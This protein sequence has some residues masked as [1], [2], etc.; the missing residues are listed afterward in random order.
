VARRWKAWVP[1]VLGNLSFSLVGRRG[2]PFPFFSLKS[3]H[4]EGGY[5]VF[6]ER[7][8]PDVKLPILCALPSRVYLRLSYGLLHCIKGESFF[9]YFMVA[10]KGDEADRAT[11]AVQSVR[12]TIHLF[13]RLPRRELH[14]F[15][16]KLDLTDETPPYDELRETVE[17]WFRQGGGKPG[18]KAKIEFTLDRQGFCEF[19]E[20]DIDGFENEEVDEKSAD[21]VADMAFYFLRDV[22]H[23]HKHH[24]R[25][26]E[27]LIH[28]Y[29]VQDGS[30]ELP[31]RWAEHLVKDLVRYLIRHRQ[32]ADERVVGVFSYLETLI[33]LLERGRKMEGVGGQEGSS[34]GDPKAPPY[35]W[36][37]LVNLPGLKTSIENELASRHRRNENQRWLITTLVVLGSIGLL[38]AYQVDGIRECLTQQP[39]LVY[40]GLIGMGLV[41]IHLSKVVLDV[42]LPMRLQCMTEPLI[43]SA[44]KRRWFSLFA[45]L[46]SVALFYVVWRIWPF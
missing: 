10:Y 1:T 15:K 21:V 20:L 6:Q 18:H 44:P 35:L 2:T 24:H 37:R 3:G 19:F 23:T 8:P 7:I 46:G 26:E 42:S 33:A 41:I 39:F 34:S 40:G 43:Q 28:A 12:G 4:L 45:V 9:R 31:L 25:W 13:T 30:E 17:G 38:Y 5:I 32:E 14:A 27:R 29:P 16:Q 36:Q 11:G 22:F